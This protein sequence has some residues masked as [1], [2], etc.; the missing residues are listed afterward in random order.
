MADL[1]RDREVLAG[2]PADRFT[3]DNRA[4]RKIAGANQR[5][6]EAV[7]FHF[8]QLQIKRCCDGAYIAGVREFSQQSSRQAGPRPDRLGSPVEAL[9]GQEPEPEHRKQARRSARGPGIA[10]RK[11]LSPKK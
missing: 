1:V 11:R 5:P 10:R 3:D 9:S 8:L 4:Q 6:L 7:R 2:G